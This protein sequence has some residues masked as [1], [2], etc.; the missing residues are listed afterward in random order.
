MSTCRRG[1]ILL[2]L[3]VVCAG[4]LRTVPPAGG[5]GEAF[6]LDG[7]WPHE[8]SPLPPHESALFGRLDNGLRYVVLQNRKP[9]GRAVVQLNVQIGSLMERDD[10]LGLA[11]FLEHM[12]FNG[13]RHFPPGELIPFFQKNGMAFGRDVNAHTS[14][15]ETV[16]TLTLAD[17]GRENLEKG[18]LILR[19][20]ADGLSIL[21]EE[22]DKERGVILAEKAARD[23]EA[24]RAGRRMRERLFGGTRFLSDP[25]GEEEV[26]RT[27]SARTI[28]EFYGAWYRPEHM[29]LVIVGGIDPGEAEESVRALFHDI[30]PHGEARTVAPWGDVALQGL[31]AYHD[32]YAAAE[33]T[34]VRI[35]TMKPRTW[36]DDSEA[37]Q[38]RMAHGAMV[39]AILS[40]RLRQLKDEG[41]V[42]L[43]GVFVR[44]TESF[45]LFP[46]TDLLA[47]CEGG[48]WR[49]VFTAL[50]DELRRA[51]EHGFLPDEV[52]AAR[53]EML[54]AYEQRARREADLHSDKVAETIV[55]CLN[56]NRVYQ[57]WA[58]TY[59]MYA[60]FFNEATA[61][62]LLAVLRDMWAADNRILA[63]TGNA[64]IDG[65]AEETLR[66]LWRQGLERP[67]PPLAGAAGF[68]FPYLP[69]PEQAGQVAARTATTLPGTELTLHEAVFAN[70]LVV[71]L[72]PTPFEQGTCSLVLHVGGGTDALDDEQARRAWLAVAANVQSGLGR[73]SPEDTRLLRRRTG[74]GVTLALGEQSVTL[75]ASGENEDMHGLLRAMWTEMRDPL[76]EE[77]DRA[78]MLASLALADA[79]RDKD[80]EGT[81]RIR[82]RQYFYGDTPR[83][84]PLTA[85]QAEAVPLDTLQGALSGLLSTEGGVLN[86]V[87][88]FDPEEALGLI[89]GLF[90]AP[91]VQWGPRPQGHPL[92]PVF[93]APDQRE[94]SFTVGA[95]L[96]QAALQVGYARNLEDVADRRALLV[97]RVL[98]SVA[99]ERL[100]ETVRE[101]LG[102]AYSPGFFYMADDDSGYGL[103]LARVNTR[104]EQLDL[105]RGALDEVLGELASGGI[106]PQEL[107]RIRR[108]MLT[109][110]AQARRENSIYGRLLN[111]VARR[112]LPYFEWDAALP[113]HLASI[114]VDDLDKEARQA[115]DPAN[116]AVLVGT[117]ALVQAGQD[118]QQQGSNP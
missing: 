22:V 97:R 9:E 111:V 116:R 55:G 72:L 92:V 104:A 43:L 113:G 105:L 117:E 106:R 78:Q 80:L 61:D 107:E 42:P 85:A 13:S 44:E 28:R 47:T 11:H 48:N 14:Y 68:E 16:Y 83:T 101:D 86:V 8:K 57:S 53:A 112:A 34:T 32:H 21:P 50:Q 114:T 63:V 69:E 51:L 90:G 103:Y 108:P 77:R 52:E 5:P 60:R 24:Y 82:S 109:A 115:F 100:R 45:N 76:L 96:G 64:A 99:R 36:S 91:G 98:A 65:D 95:A 6:W 49:A 2:T 46:S 18:L 20:V 33:S 102:A 110:W 59:E 27:A 118:A 41:Q 10:E 17:T 67:V 19:D 81:M 66:D 1:V 12:A 73:L 35:G 37:V 31:V 3:L 93:P 75:T 30:A 4:C 94:S 40:S 56:A 58:Q 39:N 88:D 25:I 26:I 71:R 89:A 84:R 74:F 15:Q 23:S 70:G 54:R 62:E 38:R 7:L 87:G 29:V 79:K